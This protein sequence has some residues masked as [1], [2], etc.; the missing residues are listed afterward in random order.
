MT[1]L[2]N[3]KM[4][5]YFKRVDFDGDGVITQK[6][7]EGMANRFIEEG[8]LADDK[9]KELKEKITELWNLYK[10][11]AD[12]SESIT[13]DA[14]ISAMS[15]LAHD[16]IKSKTQAPFAL[17]FQ[18]V[19]ANHDNNIQG[20][21]FEDFFRILGLDPKL[22]DASFKAIDTNNDGLLS[23]DEFTQAGDEFFCSQDDTLTKVFFGPLEA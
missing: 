19:D 2:W 13:Q 4:R 1:D 5:T 12:N 17:M 8:K 20:S 23:L 7:F 3:Q 11:A 6:D 18:I 9:A 22:A 16:H 10:S 15:K 21:E 14:F